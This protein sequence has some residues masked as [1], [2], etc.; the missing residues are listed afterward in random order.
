VVRCNTFPK[1]LDATSFNNTAAHTWT[2]PIKDK[3]VIYSYNSSASST[4][5][6]LANCLVVLANKALTGLS[7]RAATDDGGGRPVHRGLRF[8]RLL[9]LRDYVDGFQNYWL[10]NIE[11]GKLTK[12][13]WQ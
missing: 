5:Q 13:S 6:L 11:L 4:A 2:S 12:E 7:R 8:E 1:C 9:G 3:A 10:R